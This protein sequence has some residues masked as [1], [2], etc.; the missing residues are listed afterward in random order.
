[1]QTTTEC[2]NCGNSFTGKYCNYCGEKAFNAHEKS[3]KY[4]VGEFFHFLTHFEGNIFNTIRVIFTRPGKLSLDYCNGIRKKYY[5]PTS[6]YVLLVI[7]YLLFPMFRGLNMPMENYEHGDWQYPRHVIE[8]KM[9]KRNIS[10]DE[11]ADRFKHKSNTTSKFILLLVLPLC[12]FVLMAL[13]PRGKQFFDHFIL[14]IEINSFFL[15]SIFLVLPL[16][17]SLFYY[18]IPASRPI[19]NNE[20]LTTIVYLLVVGG[21]SAVAFRRVYGSNL[22]VSIIKAVLF[23]IMHLFIVMFLYKA[24]LF[25]VVMALL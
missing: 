17:V 24:I 11:L 16:L 14:A 1:M 7:L 5:K 15:M 6:L 2:R 21:F 13:Y 10:H 8:A 12:S 9:Q 23:L 25:T 18:T 22:V 3:I 4:I 19:V 20:D